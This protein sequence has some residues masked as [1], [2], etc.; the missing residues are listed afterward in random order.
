MAVAD[1]PSEPLLKIEGLEVAFEGRERTLGVRHASVSVKPG[2]IVGLVG[3]SGSG[4]SL[5]CRAVNRLIPRPGRITAGSVCLAG[6]DVVAMSRRELRELRAHTV[7]MVFQDPFTALNPTRRVGAQLVEVLRLHLGLSEAAAKARATELLGEMDIPDPELR[8]SS[9]PH[10]MSGGMRQRV[11]IALA[12]AAK[13][14]LLIA[15]EPTTALD[16]TTQAQILKLIMRLREETG[17]AVLFVSH[18]M[19]V[20]AQICD[21][22][23]VMYGGYVVEAGTAAEVLSDPQHPYTRALLRSVPSIRNLG[24]GRRTGIPGRPPE[25]GEILPGCPFAPRCRFATTACVEVSMEL[26]SVG[27]GH[28]TACPLVRFDSD[29]TLVT[30]TAAGRATE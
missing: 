26:E 29:G 15:D 14:A 2:T 19:G 6:R 28:H 23:H 12:I 17:M 11:M 24:I 22:I 1:P 9:Y 13:P 21:G 10:E 3:E 4:K 30:L 27:P 16:V 7:G 25:R 8:L 20:I 18:D 5:T